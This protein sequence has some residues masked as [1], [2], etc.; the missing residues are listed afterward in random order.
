M[1]KCIWAIGN[2]SGDSSKYR[3]KILDLKGLE[4]LLELSPT[5][6]DKPGFKH[7]VWGISNCCRGNPPPEYQKIS[8][9]IAFFADVLKK[10]QDLEIITDSTWAL[11]SILE[12]KGNHLQNDLYQAIIYFIRL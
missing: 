4:G 8:K 5:Q 2:L 12:S 10:E 1:N 7:L 11:V 9:A 3:D 6:I